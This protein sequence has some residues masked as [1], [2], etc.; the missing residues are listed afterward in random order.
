MR[1]SNFYC[2]NNR[3]SNRERPFPLETRQW[4]AISILSECMINIKKDEFAGNCARVF[5][6]VF[7]P[8]RAANQEI[9]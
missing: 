5:G 7:R 2:I 6:I 9:S 3:I 4:T 8:T 1:C